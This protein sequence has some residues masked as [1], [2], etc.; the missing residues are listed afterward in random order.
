MWL[1]DEMIYLD[2][3]EVP[4]KVLSLYQI[5]GSLCLRRT[6]VGCYIPWFSS[7]GPYHNLLS[8]LHQQMT[9]SYH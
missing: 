3:V 9:T 6:V 8:R 5:Q 2:M 4:D 1:V 7:N